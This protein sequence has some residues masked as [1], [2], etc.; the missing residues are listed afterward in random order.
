MH[1]SHQPLMKSKTKKYHTDE[2]V[3]KSEM[4]RGKIDIPNT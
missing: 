2:I 3:P 4:E 1:L